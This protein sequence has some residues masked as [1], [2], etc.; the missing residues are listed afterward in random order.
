MDSDDVHGRIQI[1]HGK[2]LHVP[3]GAVP[4]ANVLAVEVESIRVL[5][6]ENYLAAD[7]SFPIGR[8]DGL[9]E[10]PVA[11]RS[12]PGLIRLDPGHPRHVQRGREYKRLTPRGAYSRHNRDRVIPRGV[13]QARPS[14]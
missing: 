10:G 12:I 9:A 8:S 13:V 5:H 1:G 3:P 14:L 4:S 2:G 11:A 7:S 6:R